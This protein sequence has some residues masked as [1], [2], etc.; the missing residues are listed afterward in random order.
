V[1]QNPIAKTKLSVILFKQISLSV[2]IRNQFVIQTNATQTQ[3]NRCRWRCL[4]NICDMATMFI[5]FGSLIERAAR[6]T[7][8]HTLLHNS[9]SSPSG[10][11]CTFALY[12]SR[13]KII[14]QQLVSVTYDL[15]KGIRKKINTIEMWIYNIYILQTICKKFHSQF[16]KHFHTQQS[17][18]DVRF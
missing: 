14:L 4:Q 6:V 9:F 16:L 8:H 5:T 3:T 2:V 15:S 10:F 1:S 13:T 18:R 7:N 11:I 12:N 17:I